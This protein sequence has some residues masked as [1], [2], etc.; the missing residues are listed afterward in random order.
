MASRQYV[1]QLCR[2]APDTDFLHFKDTFGARRIE[3]ALAKACLVPDVSNRRG[4]GHPGF[5]HT[6]PERLN[7]CAALC[8]AW[9]CSWA[10][11]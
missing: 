11:R 8:S 7:W 10:S 6:R 9:S 2:V 1:T 3:S 4:E 5:P